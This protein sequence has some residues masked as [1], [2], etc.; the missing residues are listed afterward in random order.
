MYEPRRRQHSNRVVI[1]LSL[2][3]FCSQ[4]QARRFSIR[5]EEYSTTCDRTLFARLISGSPDRFAMAEALA[6]L[7]LTCSVMQVLT[8]AKELVHI[9]RRVG[10]DG[11]PEAGLASNTESFSALLATLEGRTEAFDPVTPIN[12]TK[13]ADQN[14]EDRKLQAR[15]R[16]KAL[17]GDLAK[18]VKT[19]QLLLQKVTITP[20]DGR[21]KRLKVVFKWKTGYAK[22]VGDLEKRIE[23]RRN[24]MNSEFLTRICS[25]VQASHARSDRRFS[26]IGTDIQVFVDRWADGQR[27]ITDLIAAQSQMTRKHVSQQGEKTRNRVDIQAEKTRDRID[28]IDSRIEAD[29]SHRALEEKNRLLAEL[30]GNFLNTL[31]FPEMNARENAITEAPE[32]TVGWVYEPPEDLASKCRFREWLQSEEVIFWICGKPGSGK[33]TLM[34]FLSHSPQTRSILDEWR[35]SA[36]TFSFYFVEICTNPLQRQLRGCIRSILHQILGRNSEFLDQLLQSIPALKGK[37][38]EHDWSLEELKTTLHAVLSNVSVPACLFL[39]GLDEIQPDERT[40]ATALVRE[41]GK[42]SNVKICVSSRPETPFQDRLSPYPHLR[43][44]DLNYKAIHA[45]A[46]QTLRIACDFG[47]AWLDIEWLLLHL[48]TEKAQG[49]FIWAV[50]TIKSIIRGFENHDTLETLRERVESYP[51]VLH[52]LYEQIWSRQNSDKELY[53]QDAAKLFWLALDLEHYI[54]SDAFALPKTM[55]CYIIF[56]HPALRDEMRKVAQTHGTMLSEDWRRISRT[57]EAWLSV[58]TAGLLEVYV[59]STSIYSRSI[60]S[61]TSPITSSVSSM[62]EYTHLDP[63]SVVS[64][65]TLRVRMIHRSVREFL[66]GSERG[67]DI[68]SHDQSSRRSKFLSVANAAAEVAYPISFFGFTRNPSMDQRGSRYLWPVFDLLT[69]AMQS[70][71]DRTGQLHALTECKYL[72]QDQPDNIFVQILYISLACL[73]GEMQSLDHLK[74][75]ASNGLSRRQ[76]TQMLICISENAV[77]ETGQWADYSVEHMCFTFQWLVEA[78]VDPNAGVNTL[79]WSPWEITLSHFRNIVK[80][81]S[82]ISFHIRLQPDDARKKAH[83]MANCLQS[84]LDHG[85]DPNIRVPLIGEIDNE[86]YMKPSWLYEYL[87]CLSG[88]TAWPVSAKTTDPA[89]GGEPTA[90]QGLTWTSREEVMKD[91]RA[92]VWP[93]CAYYDYDSETWRTIEPKDRNRQEDYDEYIDLLEGCRGSELPPKRS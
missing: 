74:S 51:S 11:T 64:E 13:A 92:C 44:Q 85:A 45:Y 6:A 46:E 31:W 81:Y 90:Y 53:R 17:S 5:L 4:I 21:W 10:Q 61:F 56:T 20:C 91:S 63:Q 22:K 28:L 14:D 69:E 82:I 19:L 37:R 70:E 24:V 43:V 72:V 33:S 34:K 3:P 65:L 15:M 86:L 89:S 40:E 55:K 73:L 41:L 84:F 32:E 9:C 59:D 12:D 16:L 2:S 25:S 76:L 1:L 7:S 49:V 77:I 58:R 67:Q 35:P 42:C 39:D 47:Y 60:R 26:G 57:Y 68:L 83:L 88:E 18:D 79:D 80:Y 48:V 87:R 38:S 52:D 27:T 23:A 62:S 75:Q 93:N 71:T 30:R 8:F 78:G 50:I 54:E 36:Q 29:L 66:I